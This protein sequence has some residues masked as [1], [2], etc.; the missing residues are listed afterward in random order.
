[1]Q[2]K[3]KKW[4][5]PVLGVCLVGIFPAIFLYGNNSNEVNIQEIFE[6]M[7]LFVTIALGLFV[8]S[9]LLTRDPNKSSIISALFMLVFENFAGLEGLLLALFPCLYYWHTTAI[10]IFILLHLAYLIYKFIPKDLAKTISSILCLVFV[11]LCLVNILTAIPGEVNKRNSKKLADEMQAE[12]KTV[13]LIQGNSALPNIYLLAFD[14]FS[15]FNQMEKYYQ[16][17]NTTLKSFLEEQN[18]TISYGS[19]NDSILTTTVMTN[20]VNLDY[21]V[22]NT[23]AESIKQVYRYN[24]TLFKLLENKGYEIRKLTTNKLYG[25]DYPIGSLSSSESAVT[26]TG[27]NFQTLLMKK[28]AFY[29]FLKQIVS[30]ALVIV[31]FLAN[32]FNIPTEPTFTIAH[33]T[34]SHTPFYYDENGNINPTSSWDDWVNDDVYLGIY[35]FTT[36]QIIKIV[37][38]LVKNDPNSLI[39]LMSDHGARASTNSDLF[40]KKFELTDMENT[41]NSFY[42]MGEDLSEYVDLSSVNTLRMLLNESIGTNYEK[43]QVPKD[44]YEYK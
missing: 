43:V 11:A 40:M 44:E 36:K 18:F 4:T 29:P 3:L 17:D 24:G 13:A 33:L 35:K 8:I 30:N 42:Y 2:K 7:A 41:F 38:N 28:T 32:E 31:D 37:K 10:F 39:I 34:I 12:E 22:N 20:V 14:E 9:V 16:Y 27:D 26:A 25:D 21:V 1:M 19:Y 6:P 23:T 15:G 5:I